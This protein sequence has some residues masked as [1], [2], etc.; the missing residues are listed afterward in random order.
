MRII[1]AGFIGCVAIATAVSAAPPI[2]AKQLARDHARYVGKDV[3]VSRIYCVDDRD[4]VCFAMQPGKWLKIVAGGIG[5][6]TASSVTEHVRAE[7]QGSVNLDNPACEFRVTVRVDDPM[8]KMTETG[9]GRVP[10]V[11]LFARTIE[12]QRAR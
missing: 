9:Q 3:T 10:L 11:T 4:L 5:A 12:L 1:A 7:C 6:Q 8:E 2:T